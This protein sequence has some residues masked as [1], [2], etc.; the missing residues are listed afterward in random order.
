MSNN[1]KLLS[2]ISKELNLDEW[3]L[4]YS[5][6]IKLKSA[7]KRGYLL[8]SE[9]IE[10]CNWKSPRA[11]KLIQSNKDNLIVETTYLSFKSKDEGMK[12]TEVLKIRG[13]GI[14]MASAILTL[15]FPK[16][17]CV[18][19]I[20]VWQVLYKYNFV[21]Y[22]SS[23]LGLNSKD[24]VVYIDII[25]FFSNHFNCNPRDIERTL[26]LIHKKQQVGNLY[27]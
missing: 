7:K 16:K 22:K 26:F 15:V 4:T 8:K 2:I 24:W 17:Y 5:L 14:P 13:V 27:S 18:I 25:T 9:L 12:I 11:R 19:D 6:M 21:N 10:I 23:G 1:K 20:R 3:D